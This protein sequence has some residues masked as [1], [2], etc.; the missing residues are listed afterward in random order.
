M[1]ERYKDTDLREALRRK[2]ADTPKLP[3]DFMTKMRQQTEPEPARR[4]ILWRWVAAAACL[5]IIIGIG[6][7]IASYDRMT[8]DENLMA[9]QVKSEPAGTSATVYPKETTSL[10]SLNYQFTQS[11]L[12]VQTGRTIIQQVPKAQKSD[13]KVPAQPIVEPV[14]VDENLHYAAY[15]P[16]EDSAYQAPSRMDEFIAKMADYNKVKAVTLD[17]TPDDGDCTVVSTAYVFDDKQ[18]LDLFGRLLQAACWYDSKTP[19]YLLTFSHQ[20]FFF[21]LK[22]LR[23]NEK[24]LWIAERIIGGR[25]LLYST[26][27]PIEANVSSA[28]FQEYREQLTHTNMSTLQF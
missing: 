20:Q 3:A 16:A 22:D 15:V 25:I 8:M 10:P 13:A 26:H 6:V 23:K 17:C 19:G 14:A 1:N 4:V 18:E 27:S 12:P 5:I 21:T 28:C 11:K 24:Y 9:K 7:T 2:Y